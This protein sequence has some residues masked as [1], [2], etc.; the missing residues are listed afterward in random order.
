MDLELL[1]TTF[2]TFVLT[3]VKQVYPLFECDQIG[4][5]CL[6]LPLHKSR[7]PDFF[8][9]RHKSHRCFFHIPYADVI[10]KPYGVQEL[11]HVPVK[12]KL[13]YLQIKLFVLNLLTFKSSIN[14]LYYLSVGRNALELLLLCTQISS[15]CASIPL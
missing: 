9:L 10:F 6:F 13:S 1:L 8:K 14:P 15:R 11:F 2:A 7:H 5:F 4:I 12:Q 3:P